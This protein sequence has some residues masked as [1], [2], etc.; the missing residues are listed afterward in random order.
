M[1]AFLEAK[2]E[3]RLPSWAWPNS[4]LR[5]L[6]TSTP[7]ALRPERGSQHRGTSAAQ[8]PDVPEKDAGSSLCPCPQL[9]PQHLPR[10]LLPTPETQHA[11]QWP[12]ASPQLVT[13]E[14]EHP[15]RPRR[16][17]ATGAHS[18]CSA[19]TVPS[20]HGRQQPTGLSK[21]AACSADVHHLHNGEGLHC[22]VK[23][24][25]PQN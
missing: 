1:N 18:T 14:E 2:R 5:T 9:T 6:H 19:H 3:T 7:A 25:R 4:K 24:Q 8:S 10:V 23:R 11:A 22:R 12:T 15:G 21:A 13:E 17:E 20:N 16:A